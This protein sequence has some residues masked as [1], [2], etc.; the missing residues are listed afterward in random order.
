MSARPRSATAII[1][2]D[3][4]QTARV[5]AAAH[6]GQ[7]LLTAV[8]RDRL[9]IT[10]TDLGMHTLRDIE[11]PVHLHQLG[12]EIPPLVEGREGIVSLPSPRTSLVG[13]SKPCRRSAGCSRSTRS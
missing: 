2:A 13:R 3:V 5:M 7:F 4:N 8:V 10:A 1:R 6:G 12:A 11:T 9:A